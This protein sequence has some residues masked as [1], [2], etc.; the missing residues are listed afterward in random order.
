MRGPGGRPLAIPV[1]YAK[2][3]ERGI[4]PEVW[5]RAT[6]NEGERVVFTKD[7]AGRMA[8]ASMRIMRETGKPSESKAMGRLGVV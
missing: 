3:M 7:A 5:R 8:A 1:D 4:S 2:A 6:H